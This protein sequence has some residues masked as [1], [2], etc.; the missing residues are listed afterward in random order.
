MTLRELADYLNCNYVTDFKLANRGEIP[1]FRVGG[2]GHWR[3]RWSDINRW[4][5]DRE[6]KPEGWG[7]REGKGRGRRPKSG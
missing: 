2:G 3:C 7:G 4:I 1:A 6:V 5:A